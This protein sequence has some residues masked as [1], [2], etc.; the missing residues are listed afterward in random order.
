M[1]AD[2]KKCSMEALH[3][4]L[5]G[6]S[7]KLAENATFSEFGPVDSSA[8]DASVNLLCASQCPQIRNITTYFSGRAS[9]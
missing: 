9:K 8:I 2:G 7:R 3:L 5:L 6:M 1:E 4:A